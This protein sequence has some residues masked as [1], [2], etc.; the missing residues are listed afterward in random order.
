M[1]IE[2]TGYERPQR[3]A[4]TTRMSSHGYSVHPDVRARSRGDLD[5]VVGGPGAAWHP[6]GD[7]AVGRL[8]GPAIGAK[9]LDGP[10]APPRRVDDACRLC[11]GRPTDASTRWEAWPVEPP[12]S[13]RWHAV[14]NS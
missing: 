6:Q 2:Y 13:S 5:A 10:Q 8:D 1:V 3:L 12:T 7:H 14:G 9:N 11:V 4:S